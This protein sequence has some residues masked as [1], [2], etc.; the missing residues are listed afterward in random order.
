MDRREGEGGKG[1]VRDGKG[2]KSMEAGQGVDGELEKCLSEI[3][4]R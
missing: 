2:M 4:E 1:M 3:G